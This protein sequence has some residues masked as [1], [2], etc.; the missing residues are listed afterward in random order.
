MKALSILAILVM[1]A[2]IALPASAEDE[3]TIKARMADRVAKIDKLK[4]DQVVGESNA[5]LLEFQGPKQDEGLV[6]AENADRKA[7]YAIIAQRT[8]TSAAQV[9]K[10]RA[11]EIRR[12]S[13]AGVMVQLPNGAW[14]E[15]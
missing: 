1:T 2:F 6:N 14:I 9:A 4:K 13:V 3:G 10:Q 7:V 12:Q 5:G 15:K 8:G 11:E